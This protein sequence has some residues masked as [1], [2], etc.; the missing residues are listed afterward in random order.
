MLEKLKRFYLHI[1]LILFL[2]STGQAQ[3]NSAKNSF[4]NSE[5][6]IESEIIDLLWEAGSEKSVKRKEKYKEKLHKFIKRAERRNLNQKNTQLFLENLFFRV[7]N[8]FLDHYKKTQVTT[9][10]QVFS[11]GSYD[12]VTGTAL[13]G[14]ILAQLGY[15][16]Q[17]YET[18]YH[19][20]LI[21]NYDDRIAMIESTDSYYGF[22]TEE[23]RID[24]YLGY[25]KLNKSHQVDGYKKLSYTGDSFIGLKELAGLLYYNLAVQ[26][27]NNHNYNNAEFFITRAEQ[28]YRSDR[29]R[30]IRSIIEQHKASKNILSFNL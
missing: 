30:E 29:M 6:D 26:E 4:L 5:V 19:V 7:H 15:E 28:L 25:Y 9:F 23:K 27:L 16:V 24:S 11:N 12:C 14:L 20:L 10:E 21:I 8:R 2:F 18:T 17:V 3:N 1:A 22:I 13:Y